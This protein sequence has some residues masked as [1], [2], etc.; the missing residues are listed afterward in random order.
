VMGD[1]DGDGDLDL[2]A[3]N[4]GQTKKRYL[5][6]GSGGFS[7]T[8]TNVGS[9]VDN[10]RSVV[11]GDVDSDGDLDLIAGNGSGQTNKLYLN[12]GSGGFSATGTA[13]GSETDDTRSVVLGDVDSDGDLDLI[14]GNRGHTNKLYLNNGSGGFSATGTNVGSETDSTRSV[15]LGDLDGDGDLDLIAG[16]EAQTKKRYLN[17]AVADSAR[18]APTWAVKPTPPKASCWGMWTAMATST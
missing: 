9:E 5:N 17:N 12:N 18:P 6:D 1:L 7:A 2:I 8:G 16:N 14:A 3:G 11:L 13:I 10:T 4:A 15:V